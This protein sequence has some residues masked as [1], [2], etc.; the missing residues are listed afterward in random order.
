[1]DWKKRRKSI[2]QD[3]LNA[4][5]TKE[6][7]SYGEYPDVIVSKP[8]AAKRAYY[9]DIANA[10]SVSQ[11]DAILDFGSGTG[12]LSSVFVDQFQIPQKRITAVDPSQPML[13]ILNERFPKI[14]TECEYI[15]L[16]ES[17]RL[18]KKSSFDLVVSRYAANGLADPIQ[19]FQNIYRWIKPGGHCLLYTSDAADE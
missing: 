9:E 4:Y 2:R 12:T 13:C 10:V 11:N 5:S 1:M 7:F 8:V 6:A 14:R 3:Y 19:G 17:R 16:P 15:D 18:F